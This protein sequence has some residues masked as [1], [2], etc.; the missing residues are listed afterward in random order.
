MTT[1]ARRSQTPLHRILQSQRESRPAGARLASWLAR[2][3]GLVA[4]VVYLGIA[5]LW[6]RSVIAH[7]DANC[8]CGLSDDPGDGAV[9]VWW[10]EWFVHALGSGLPLM[11]TTVMWT[12]T[13]LNMYG[14]TASLLYAVV[15]A[16]LTLIWGP[17]V[18]F[19]VTM[20]L[21]PVLSGW[22][23]NRLCRQITGSVSAS[24][25]GGAA[26]GFS[27][28]EIGHMVGHVN[29]AMMACP[30]LVALCVLRLLA[31]E[32]RSDVLSSR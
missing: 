25:V 5:V 24:L 4:F 12:P 14:T 19:N 11:H 28:Y 9:A 29:I 30:P 16:P 7:M 2:H 26:F 15:S 22:A 32:K 18:P 31:G 13:G 20:I 21:A 10:L 8:A 23:A 6:Y 27:T 3:D 1:V 17:I